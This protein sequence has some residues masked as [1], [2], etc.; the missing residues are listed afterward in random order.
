MYI[1][2]VDYG[3]AHSNFLAAFFPSATLFLHRIEQVK[4]KQEKKIDLLS[5]RW[6][7]WCFRHIRFGD[8]CNHSEQFILKNKSVQ[9]HTD[10]RARPSTVCQCFCFSF[11]C[12]NHLHHCRR[13][14]IMSVTFSN[15]FRHPIPL[16]LRLFLHNNNN[17]IHKF[18]EL[19]IPWRVVNIVTQTRDNTK[20]SRNRNGKV[21]E[22]LQ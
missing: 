13:E 20:N 19:L 18:E 17:W 1:D 12:A 7:C 8:E 10:N 15:A 9:L 6:K 14:K 16:N 4:S 11:T 21:T 3:I 5:E 2:Q 22:I